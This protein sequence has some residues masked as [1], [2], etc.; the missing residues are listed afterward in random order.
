MKLI[1]DSY[2]VYN[3]GRVFDVLVFPRHENAWAFY[4][5][6]DEKYEIDGDKAFFKMLLY[7]LAVLADNP[8]KIIYFPIRHPGE[9]MYGAEETYDAVLLRPELPFRR[10]DWRVVRHKLDRKHF[11]GKYAVHYDSATMEQYW[12]EYREKYP[13]HFSKDG[14][15]YCGRY[16]TN[17]TEDLYA[18]TVFL[19][20]PKDV[21]AVYHHLIMNSM[22]ELEDKF[23]NGMYVGIGYIMS[24]SAT[25]IMQKRS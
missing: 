23:P 3:R 11:A 1:V 19:V 16:D 17:I 13:W 14:F 2:S 24:P 12:Q 22:D 9:T 21:C 6:D 15:L 7:A 4:E 8:S 20:L 10:S 25:E 18:S 5:S